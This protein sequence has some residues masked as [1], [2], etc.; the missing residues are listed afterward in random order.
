M[1]LS[2][3]ILLSALL[4]TAC[5]SEPIVEEQD[6]QVPETIDREGVRQTI[7]SGLREIRNC[8]EVLA[9]TQPKA[10]GK[11]IVNLAINSEGKAVKVETDKNKSTMTD[12][13]FLNCMTTRIASWKFPPAKPKTVVDIIYPFYFRPYAGDSDKSA[14]ADQTK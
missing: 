12:P 5:A 6:H 13:N 14:S 9:K 11:V 2:L 8:Y 10:E 1:K 3:A 4:M 7:R